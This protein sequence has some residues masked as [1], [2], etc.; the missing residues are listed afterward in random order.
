[1]HAPRSFIMQISIKSVNILVRIPK[2][3]WRLI[4][5]EKEHVFAQ[6]FSYLVSPSSELISSFGIVLQINCFFS[7]SLHLN[8]VTRLQVRHYLCFQLEEQIY[9]FQYFYSSYKTTKFRQHLW[10]IDNCSDTATRI[11]YCLNTLK[12]YYFTMILITCCYN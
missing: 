2:H 9:V 3:F 11:K 7:I 12:K 8:Y 5:F 10:H 6:F 4:W 1:M